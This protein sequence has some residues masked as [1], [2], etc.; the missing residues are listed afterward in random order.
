[1][2]VIGS[3]NIPALQCGLAVS[4]SVGLVG[5]WL[6][7][8]S[9]HIIP[10]D[11]WLSLDAPSG[12]RVDDTGS[13]EFTDEYT[14]KALWAGGTKLADLKPSDFFSYGD[15]EKRA[16]RI[17]LS[18]RGSDIGPRTTPGL[19]FLADVIREHHITSMIDVPCGDANWQFEA[20]ETEAIPVYLGLDIVKP[21]IDFNKRRF[22][23][24][25][26]KHFHV[27]DMSA[28]KFPRFIKSG[29]RRSTPFQLIHVRDVIQH[30]PL[31]RGLNALANVMNSGCDFAVMTT[32]PNG[33]NGHVKEMMYYEAN[34]G[35]PPFDAIVPKPIKCIESHFKQTNFTHESDLTCLYRCI[36]TRRLSAM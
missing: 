25:A 26:N 36:P 23:H 3:R 17:S 30:L 28:C 4:V 18:G 24:H 7:S 21:L 29:N 12:C 8:G 20:W 27:W 33:K 1:M 19:N 2:P 34:L 14:N 31:Q 32:F 22:E 9:R 16:S 10:V 5:L 15:W 13:K 35:A 6:W 11:P